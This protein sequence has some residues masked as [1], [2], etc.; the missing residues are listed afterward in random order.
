M[1]T[2]TTNNVQ[3]RSD[4]FQASCFLRG[5][6]LTAFASTRLHA[7]TEVLRQLQHNK[8]IDV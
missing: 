8:E 5:V 4:W 7:L 1:I 3:G 2:I 6:V